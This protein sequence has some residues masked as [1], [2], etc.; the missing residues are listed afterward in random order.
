MN[1]SGPAID[2]QG[3][4]GLYSLYHSQHSVEITAEAAKKIVVDIG[5]QAVSWVLD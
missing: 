3:L 1:Q 4:C 5:I 2:V